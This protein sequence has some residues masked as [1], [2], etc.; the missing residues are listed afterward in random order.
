MDHYQPSKKSNIR[1]AN[2]ERDLSADRAYQFGNNDDFVQYGKLQIKNN[3]EHENINHPGSSHYQ[4]YKQGA[5]QIRNNG[6]QILNP[7]ASLQGAAGFTSQ[8]N[9]IRANSGNKF[10]GISDEEL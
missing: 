9:N 4:Q 8:R 7:K 5:I 6:K 1:I 10:S 2:G 3:N